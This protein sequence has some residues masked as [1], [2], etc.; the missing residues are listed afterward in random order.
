MHKQ[1]GIDKRNMI[2]VHVSVTGMIAVNSY[3]FWWK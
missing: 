1:I 3:D 2:H